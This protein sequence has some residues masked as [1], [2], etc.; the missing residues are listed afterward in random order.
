MKTVQAMLAEAGAE[1]PRISQDEAKGLLGDLT[2]WFSP[3]ACRLRLKH[4]ER[5]QGRS[6]FREVLW[7][8][9]PTR[10]QLFMTRRSTEPR[11]SLHIAALVDARRW[12]ARR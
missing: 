5:F 9:A 4:R 3:F 12:S 11:Q 1:V 2:C 8:F 6:P 10:P 7:N